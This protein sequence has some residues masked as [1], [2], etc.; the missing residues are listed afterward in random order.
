MKMAR[1]RNTGQAL[2]ETAITVPIL[3]MLLLSFLLA[4]VVAQAY[5]D[6][7]TATGLAAASAVSAPAGSPAS[8]DFA[9]KTYNGTLLLTGYLQPGSL[10]GCGAY[11]AGA[12]VTCVGH[13]TLLLSKTPMAVL[14]PFNPNWTIDIQATATA[15]SSQYRST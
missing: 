12:S 15:Y 3:L 11:T 7:D 2:I 8:W 13:A 5:V 9:S 1:R 4:M 14:Q 6:L 10:T